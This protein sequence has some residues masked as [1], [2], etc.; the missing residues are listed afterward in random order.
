MMSFIIFV[1]DVTDKVLSHDSNYIVYVVMW[2]KFGNSSISMKEVIEGCCWLKFNNLGLALGMA[3]K[4]Y[5]SVTKGLKI[6][7]RKFE[8]SERFGVF[9]CVMIGMWDVGDVECWGCRIFGTWIWKVWDVRCLRCE[10]FGMWDLG[11]VR[12]G[13]SAG[14]WDVSFQNTLNNLV[15]S[16]LVFL[17]CIV[18]ELS[19]WRRPVNRDK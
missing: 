9:G 5:T 17:M 2:P 13:V 11:D 7:V 8:M 18:V 14:M 19:S 3:L 6:K 12:C 10:V 4:F 15:A 16:N 1:F